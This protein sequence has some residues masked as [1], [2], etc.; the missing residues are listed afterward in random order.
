MKK[1]L[2]IFIILFSF[3]NITTINKQPIP[4]IQVKETKSGKH[5]FDKAFNN[6]QKEIPEIKYMKHH[7]TKLARIESTFNP[8]AKNKYTP[9][10]GY[11]QLIEDYNGVYNISKYS[12]LSIYNF[13]HNPEEQIKAAYKLTKDNEKILKPKFTLA[14]QKGISKY[15]LLAIAHFA[16][17]GGA[18]KFLDKHNEEVHQ[19]LIKYKKTELT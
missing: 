17:V 8:I 11:F 1:L 5:Y 12:G 10:Y 15:E 6:V 13:I 9:A 16:G 14:K 18:I 4:K 2:L 3:Q 7:L 19:Y